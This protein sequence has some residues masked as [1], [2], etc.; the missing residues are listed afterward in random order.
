MAKHMRP[1]CSETVL[2]P[3]CGSHVC[4]VL[5]VSVSSQDLQACLLSQAWMYQHTHRP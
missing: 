5:Q 4:L 1:L 2:T 3:T